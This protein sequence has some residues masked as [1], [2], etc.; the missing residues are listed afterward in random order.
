VPNPTCSSAPD[1][2]REQ[3]V[4]LTQLARELG[5]DRSVVERWWRRGV[6]GH[7]LGTAL[8]G[9][10]RCTSREEFDRWQRRVNGLP[11]DA[12]SPAQVARSHE[13]VE[14]ELDAAGF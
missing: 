8:D 4:G 2:L 13:R 10:R 5:R 7:R 1:I 3:K 14:R 12:L 6:R 9:G 11:A